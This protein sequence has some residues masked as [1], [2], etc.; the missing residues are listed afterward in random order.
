M[1][2][3]NNLKN[4]ID[5][6]EQNKK[7]KICLITSNT[8]WSPLEKIGERYPNYHID[9]FGKIYRL[10]YKVPNMDWDLMIFFSSSFTDPFE[11]SI[12][13]GIAK[14]ISVEYQKRVTVGYLSYTYSFERI[15]LDA[16]MNLYLSSFK[17]GTQY[18]E[19]VSIFGDDILIK[20]PFSI[21][22]MVVSKYS[23]IEQQK[24]MVK[25]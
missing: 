24:V 19:I 3:V 14:T 6:L 2:E 15:D 13:R 1:K 12:L 25:K 21:F 8:F 17:K 7:M 18:D 20:D 10:K 9:I 11:V 5:G 4:N 22:D 23:E 16:T